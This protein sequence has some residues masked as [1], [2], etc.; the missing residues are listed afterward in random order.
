MRES[1]EARPRLV[2]GIAFPDYWLGWESTQRAT[3]TA[4]LQCC[5]IKQLSFLGGYADGRRELC[6]GFPG[7]SADRA[8]AGAGLPG[9]CVETPRRTVA[10]S[11][12]A[13]TGRRRLGAQ[14]I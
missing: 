6:S 4:T 3:C 11:G 12:G 7:R 1:S 8:R 14:R 9:V 2:R 5:N 10:V 13:H